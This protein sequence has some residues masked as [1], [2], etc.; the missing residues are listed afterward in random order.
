MLIGIGHQKR[1]GKDRFAGELKAKLEELDILSEVRGFAYA[2]KWFAHELFGSYNLK[3]PEYYDT[4]PEAKSAPLHEGLSRKSARN[5]W[6]EY[7]NAMRQIVPT[8][9]VDHLLEDVDSGALGDSVI[10]IPDVRFA[11][12]AQAIKDRGGLLIKM[13][14]P[15]IPVEAD[16]ADDQLVL[17]RGWDYTIFNDFRPKTLRDAAEEVAAYIKDDYFNA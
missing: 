3:W 2:M 12:E 17:Y 14:N 11:Q 8:I 5:V 13:Y 9:W 7:A 10:I 16:G 1:I 4:Y 15:N 6:I